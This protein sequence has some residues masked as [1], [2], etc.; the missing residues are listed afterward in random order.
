MTVDV[1]SRETPPYDILTI[2]RRRGIW[3]LI[4]VVILQ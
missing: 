4:G 2:G 3:I 1:K